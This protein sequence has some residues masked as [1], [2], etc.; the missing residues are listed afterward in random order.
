MRAT[1]RP[2]LAGWRYGYSLLPAS[3][4][5]ERELARQISQGLATGQ[6]GKNKNPM[7]LRYAIVAAALTLLGS[8]LGHA[9]E[10]RC[11]WYINPT[12]GNLWLQD[13]QTIWWI[14]S[15]NQAEGPDAIGADDNA[16]QMNGKEYVDKGNGHGHGCACLTVD[17]DHK[18]KITRV[19][20]GK[21]IPLARCKADKTLPE[22]AG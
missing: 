11:G 16:P 21:T 14:T 19:Y 20:S 7:V 15:Q 5:W 18:E 9:A 12:P 1:P 3:K 13:T 17:T 8:T 4:K 6:R 10:Q 2:P 22:P